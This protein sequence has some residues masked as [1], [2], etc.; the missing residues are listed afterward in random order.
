MPGFRSSYTQ[1]QPVFNY[2]QMEKIS[3]DSDDDDD[4]VPPFTPPQ[5]FS[6]PSPP[7][8]IHNP[9]LSMPSASSPQSV[10]L[11]EETN[12]TQSSSSLVACTSSYRYSYNQLALVVTKK[13]YLI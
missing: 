3:D 4:D 10:S 2:F 8:P 11:H 13:L 5:P 6:P 9:T 7:S 1:H 12:A